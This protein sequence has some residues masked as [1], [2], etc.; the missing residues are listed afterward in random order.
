MNVM[1]SSKVTTMFFL[2][3]FKLLIN[4]SNPQNVEQISIPMDECDEVLFDIKEVGRVIFI[5]SCEEY[6]WVE[7]NISIIQAF[8]TK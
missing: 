2:C 4:A 7:V 3:L 6:C 8:G 5:P 1:K